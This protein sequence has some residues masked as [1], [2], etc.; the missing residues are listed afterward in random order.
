MKDSEFIELLNLYLDHEISSADA[1]R[2]DAE[3]QGNPQRRRVYQEYCRMQKACVLIAQ[4][5]AAVP[6]TEPR[7]VIPFEPSRTW[8]FNA[9]AAGLCAAAACIAVVFIA[10]NRAQSALDISGGGSTSSQIAAATPSPER[11]VNASEPRSIARTVSV[12]P[13]ANGE[14][15]PVFTA[16]SLA[17]GGNQ[18]TGMQIMPV[19]DSRFEW[20]NGVQLSSL[21]RMPA[22]ELIFDAKANLPTESR[23]FR[24]ERSV[25]AQVERTAFQ[26]QR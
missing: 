17:L 13:R 7:N 19:S 10:R 16:H 15:K 20:M 22:E 9:Y 2:L 8:G 12:A 14:L 5:P 24:S 18:S 4:N 1:V 25:D 6:L 21:N 3:V 11:G 23:T 26:F